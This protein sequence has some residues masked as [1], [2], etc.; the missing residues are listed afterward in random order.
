MT[1]PQHPFRAHWQP[2]EVE[3]YGY[4][5]AD[6]IEAT[7]LEAITS[8]FKQHPNEVAKYP[9]GLFP[10]IDYYDLELCFRVEHCAHLLGDSAGDTM[11][12]MVR[13]MNA[14]LR[15]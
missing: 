3:A 2:I 11:R 7:A 4:R 6:T 12:M 9:I 8:F 5:F 14:Q 10:A 13:F 15:H 1:I